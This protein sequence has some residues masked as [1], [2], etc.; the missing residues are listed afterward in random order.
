M[1][2]WSNPLPQS[3]ATKHQ[4]LTSSGVLT[5]TIWL[6]VPQRTARSRSVKWGFTAVSY[7]RSSC[8]QESFVCFWSKVW[9]IPDRGLTSAMTEASVTL[10]EHSKRVGILAW[11]PTAHNIL[12]TAGIYLLCLSVWFWITGDCNW[13]VFVWIDFTWIWRVFKVPHVHKWS[14]VWLD[15]KTKYIQCG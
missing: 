4:C 13:V 11:H 9:Q 10:E 5:M 7:W 14:K 3:T 8:Q 12:L 2:E 6:Q 1:A 15:S